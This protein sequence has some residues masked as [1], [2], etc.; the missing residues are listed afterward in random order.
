MVD[1]RLLVTR[2]LTMGLSSWYINPPCYSHRAG[3]FFN[4][5]T[6]MTIVA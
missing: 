5:T 3:R 1:I 4:G 6:S 2:V